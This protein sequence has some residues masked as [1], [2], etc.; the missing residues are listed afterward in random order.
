MFKPDFK[1]MELLPAIAQDAATG[2]VLMLAYMNEQ[3]WNA[4]LET[5]EAHYWSRSRQEL[6]HKGGTSGH[7]QKVK[8]IRLDCDSDTVLLLIE[9]V[10]GAACHKGYKSCFYRELKDGQVRECSPVVFDPKEV[11][12]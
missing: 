12:R 3:A 5:G 4:T 6:W 7:V 11:Y 9:Q 8:S 1:K 10:G 2:E